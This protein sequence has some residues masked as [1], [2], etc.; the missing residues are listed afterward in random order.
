MDYL[1]KKREFIFVNTGQQQIRVHVQQVRGIK[2]DL[3]I[4][5]RNKPFRNAV[6]K[7]TQILSQF[8]LDKLAPIV[9]IGENRLGQGGLAAYSRAQDVIFVS[10]VLF[11]KNRYKLDSTFS[12]R[13]LSQIIA[14]ELSH[15]QHWD[16]VKRFHYANRFR[17]ND[18][19]ISKK[20][21]D[22]ELERYI[23]T[24]SILLCK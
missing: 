9:I 7:L 24:L 13:N 4:E 5:H 2:Y 12:E 20:Y 17:Y 22:Q 11:E 6:L 14:H 16:A 10:T 21:L 23:S 1:A 8:N 19:Q 15:K 3:W 18:L